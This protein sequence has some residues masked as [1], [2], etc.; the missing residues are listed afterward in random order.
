[1]VRSAKSLPESAN[2]VA[3]EPQIT[4]DSAE[5]RDSTGLRAGF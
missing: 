1:M 2:A 5:G 3:G 4:F